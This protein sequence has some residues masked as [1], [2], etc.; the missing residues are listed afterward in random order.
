[1]SDVKIARIWR[2]YTIHLFSIDAI[3]GNEGVSRRHVQWAIDEYGRRR[4]RL[5]AA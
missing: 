4:R 2:L 1:M 5:A 3:A